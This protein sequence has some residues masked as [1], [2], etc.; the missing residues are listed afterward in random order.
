[1]QSL[2][3]LIVGSGIAGLTCAGLLK[4]Q[5]ASFKIIEKEKVD[6]FNTSGYMLGILPLGGRVMTELNLTEEYNSRSVEMSEYEIHKENGA[7]IKTY[8]LGF[9]NDEYG[10]YRGIERKLLIDIMLN[11]IGKDSV[12]FGTTINQIVLSNNGVNITFS[13]N[14]K[15]FF[16][17]VIVADGMHSET[18]SLLWARNEYDYYDTHW[19][20]WVEWISNQSLTSYKEYWGAGSFLG[21]YPVKDHIGLFLGGPDNVIKK[22]GLK[23][24]AQSIKS[25]IHPEHEILHKALDK[26]AETRN[27]YYWELHD[28]R[29]KGWQKG[30][31]IL[32]GDAASGFLPTAGVGA[33]MAMD[34]AASLVDELSRTDRDHIEYGLRLYVKNQKER[35]ER[36]QADSRKLGKMM[37]IESK[38]IS[39]ARDFATRFYTLQQ[40]VKNISKTIE[41]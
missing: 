41:G 27:P 26:L 33:S 6:D 36:A 12:L 30:N 19:G 31:V 2:N 24:F 4:Q 40:L 39:K 7:L 25:E 1:M 3:I 5:G 28:V 10:S 23:S 15:E 9:I 18:R 35:V 38:I 13:D 14:T 17:L 21:L 20:G 16:D 22:Q 8:S 37:F 32:L 29:T 34:S 11:K